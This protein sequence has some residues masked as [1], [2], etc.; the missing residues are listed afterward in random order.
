M[1]AQANEIARGLPLGPAIAGAAALD[2]SCWTVAGPHIPGLRRLLVPPPT[3]PD[4]SVRGSPRRGLST[5][6]GLAADRA[7]RTSSETAFAAWLCV[8][9]APLT[10]LPCFSS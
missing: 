5:P 9:G 2:S 10:G 4:R 1:S 3:P 7:R 6:A 8:N